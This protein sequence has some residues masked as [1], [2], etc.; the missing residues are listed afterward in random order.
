MRPRAPGLHAAISLLSVRAYL[1]PALGHWMVFGSRGDGTDQA[2]ES[3]Q[4]AQAARATELALES[5]LSQLHGARA[6]VRRRTASG[7]SA[8]TIASTSSTPS[9]S[10]WPLAPGC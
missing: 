5:A 1:R 10:V 9:L 3:A 4:A 6:E 2:E 8:R 7:H